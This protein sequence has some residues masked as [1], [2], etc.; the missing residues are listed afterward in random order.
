VPPTALIYRL[1]LESGAL[2]N[3]SDLWSAYAAIM[4]CDTDEE[5]AQTM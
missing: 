2:I 4:E 5:K 1:Y 3:A